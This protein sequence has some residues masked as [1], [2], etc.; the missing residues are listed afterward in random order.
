MDNLTLKI[1]K[2]D[3]V[4][5]DEQGCTA[6]THKKGT[7]DILSVVPLYHY[8]SNTTSTNIP[9]AIRNIRLQP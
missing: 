7:T 6:A 5:P 8:W 3:S 2:I 4:A 9:T 1:I